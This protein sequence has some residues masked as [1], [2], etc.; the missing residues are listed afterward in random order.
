MPVLDK[1]IILCEGDHNSVRGQEVMD[2]ASVFLIR[3][4]QVP[5]KLMIASG[6][7]GVVS[8]RLLCL[9]N[10]PLAL[11][12]CSLVLAPTTYDDY[13]LIIFI[14]TV[15][16]NDLSLLFLFFSLSPSDYHGAPPPPPAIWDMTTLVRR[17]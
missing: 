15:N 10:A 5:E 3:S 8:I 12:L 11:V 7:N 6:H 2:N 13:I 9:S 1:N 4:L 14:D 16:T 17:I